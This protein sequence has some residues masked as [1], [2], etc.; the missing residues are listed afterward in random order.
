MGIN[1]NRRFATI[2]FGIALLSAVLLFAAP[3]AALQIVYPADRTYVSKS[4]YL[5]LKTADPQITGV[6]VTLNGVE[7]DLIDISDEVYRNA[8][9][10]II[11]LLPNWRPGSNQIVVAGFREGRRMAREAANIVYLRDL[12]AIPPK[13]FEPFVMH[14]PEGEALCAPCHIMQPLPKGVR[15]DTAATNP[16]GDCHQGLLDKKYVHGPAGVWEC[17]YCHLPDSEPNR[18]RLTASEA[19]LCNSCHVGKTEEFEQRRFAHGPVGVGLCTICHDPHASNQKAYLRAKPNEVC[20]ACHEGLD[21]GTHVV[22][23]VGGKGHP[24]SGPVNPLDE[25]KEFSCVS[26]HDPHGGESQFLFVRGVQ[27]KFGLCNLCHQK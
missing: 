24:L 9:G 3:A 15:A 21:Q 27:T 12:N 2:S 8:F 22:R 13:G 10:D 20:L 7:S 14:T 1:V 25:R 18:H 23:G 5:I 11:I 26:C 4:N 6:T 19:E 17:S 16:C